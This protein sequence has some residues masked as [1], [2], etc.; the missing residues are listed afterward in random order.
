MDISQKEKVLKSAIGLLLS[1]V[2]FFSSGIKV[3]GLDSTAETYFQD[4]IAK[5]GVSYG[6]CRLI[7]GTVS[8]I[9][10]SSVQLEPAGIG[11]SLAV[12]Q[13]VDPINDMV[14]RLS[15]VLVL[16]ITSLGIQ[17]LAYEISITLAPPICASFLFVLSVLLWFKKDTF[18]ALQKVVLNVLIIVSIARFCLPVSSLANEFLQEHF[19]EDKIIEANGKLAEGMADLNTLNEVDVP[20]YEGVLKTI[21][22][23]ASYI[24]HKSVDFKNA[25]SIT[26]ENKG[27]IVENLLKLT[28]LYLGIFVIQILVLPLAIFW[29]LMRLVNAL[30][31]SNVMGNSTHHSLS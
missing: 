7:N 21:E 22:N 24:K 4:S 28:F 14:E 31:L 15:D 25:V 26:L 3:P 6:V 9:Q 18:F 12:G 1:V 13:I 27:L 5:A 20:E 30:F 17:E 8:V 23:S 10:Q 2:L 29:L 11:M 19:F 16:S